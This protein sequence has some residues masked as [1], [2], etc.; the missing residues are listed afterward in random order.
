MES[1][2]MAFNSDMMADLEANGSFNSTDLPFGD[3]NPLSNDPLFNNGYGDG[4]GSSPFQFNTTPSWMMDS[5]GR[6]GAPRNDSSVTAIMTK[7]GHDTMKPRS[8]Q[9]STSPES[10]SESA[11]SSQ[12]SNRRKRK[13]PTSQ[14]TANTK[15]TSLSRGDGPPSLSPQNGAKRPAGAGGKHAIHDS[16]F[17][18]GTGITPDS[19]AL[20]QDVDNISTAMTTS[21]LFDFDSAASSPGGFHPTMDNSTFDALNTPRTLGV[22]NLP[23]TTSSDRQPAKFFLQSRDNSPL[24]AMGTSEQAS[25][26][27]MFTHESPATVNGMAL[28]GTMWQSHTGSPAWSNNFTSG[29]L[30]GLSPSPAADAV[31][32]PMT[33]Q[34]SLKKLPYNLTVR[35][36]NNKSRVE[37][38]IPVTL[39]MHPFPQSITKIHL[40]SQT[41]SK[42]KLL[43][44]DPVKMADTLELHASVFCTSAMQKPHLKERAFRRAAGLPDLPIKREARRSSTGD[45]DEEE[46]DPNEPLNGGEVKICRNCV[47]RER[48]RAARKKAKKQEDEDHWSQFEQDRIVVFNTAEY[49]D[50]SPYVPRD[51]FSDGTYLDGAMQV[52]M[53]MRIACYCRHQGEKTG[54]QVIFT[55][56][57]HQDRVVAQ[58]IS[59][60]ILITDDHKTQAPIAGANGL[61]AVEG[62]PL[63]GMPMF[64]QDMPQS[65][66]QHRPYHSVNDLQA[67]RANF[68]PQAFSGMT[69][70]QNQGMIPQSV[71]TSVTPRNLSRPASPTAHI[72]P[73]KKRKGSSVHHKIP[74][75]LTMTRVSGPQQVSVPPATSIG[76][77]SVGPMSAGPVLTGADQAFGAV[78]PLNIPPYQSQ[79]PTPGSNTGFV[80]PINRTASAENMQMYQFYSAPNS[81]HPSRVP[82]P[83]AHSRPPT[84]GFQNQAMQTQVPDMANAPVTGMSFSPETAPAPRATITRINPAEGPMSGGIQIDIHGT[85]LY[86]GVRVKFGDQIAPTTF[87]NEGA[88]YA[89]LPPSNIAGPVE[90]TLLHP[91]ETS[92]FFQPPSSRR[93]QYFKYID[94]REQAIWEMFGKAMCA[95]QMGSIDANHAMAFLQ[96]VGAQAPYQGGVDNSI[97]YQQFQQQMAALAIARTAGRTED[98]LLEVLN[99]IDLDDSPYA[100]NFDVKRRNGASMLSLASSL[101]YTRLVAG[102]VAR[103]ATVDTR[104]KSGFTPLMLAAMTGHTHIV[105]LLTR[106][107]AD[108]NMRNKLGFTATELAKSAEV[109]HELQQIPYHIKA[110]SVGNT[111]LFHSRA[112]SVVFGDT[113]WMH[114]SPT[115]SSGVSLVTESD[116]DSQAIEDDDNDDILAI[117]DPRRINSRRSSGIQQ[118]SRRSS[119]RPSI[120]VPTETTA[121]AT[122]PVAAMT[123]WRDHLVEQINHFQHYASELQN[124]MPNIPDVQMVRRFSAIMPTFTR[125]DSFFSTGT[126]PPPYEEK[127]PVSAKAAAAAETKKAAVLEAVAEAALDET[128]AQRFDGA[129]AGTGPRVKSGLVA[130][131]NKDIKVYIGKKAITKEQQ[132]QLRLAHQARL[133]KGVSDWKMWVIWLPIL[134]CIVVL[135]TRNSLPQIKGAFTTVRTSI[136]DVTQRLA[137]GV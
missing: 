76:P 75:G 127:D 10:S 11:A 130:I 9:S 48:K 59:D 114:P 6:F 26:T 23:V 4:M 65:S 132:I 45:I 64:T 120:S 131:V 47:N 52:E 33:I 40:Q 88:L 31:N 25:P 105:R 37:T 44:K 94:D 91:N 121:L 81:A 96:S 137:M 51:G 41:I 62:Y 68:P 92:N 79:P 18:M 111:P 49:K 129:S 109:E 106:K 29:G 100:P 108:P 39:I 20:G 128:C 103:G 13:S 86:N 28:D 32:S 93:T 110:K 113:T 125:A 15:T 21:N 22:P 30:A 58:S 8:N 53:P 124:R 35:P 2:D 38:Q 99:L 101:G 74:P 118:L 55:L 89:V 69:T 104:D 97:N 115:N 12:S 50:W 1:E 102:L 72:G 46:T 135:M 116:D 112:N 133:K 122:S 56:K 83:I 119:R 98:A 5:P 7:H 82:S 85:D 73:N 123:V 67:L 24:D 84:R 71:S 107:G 17:S 126:P 27:A 3:D 63:A 95:K 54:F 78:T 16:G 36:V 61:S 136:S 19:I 90:V 87:W 60:S 14:D 66:F 34:A 134:I 70:A 42:P 80:T 57:D 117:A 77:T 43:A